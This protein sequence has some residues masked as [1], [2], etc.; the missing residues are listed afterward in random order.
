LDSGEQRSYI[1]SNAATKLGLHPVGEEK[2]SHTL[3]GGV[4]T[5]AKSVKSYIVTSSNTTGVSMNLNLLKCD[6]ICENLPT[7]NVWS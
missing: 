1:T 7:L 4:C 5:G 3:F 2:L 6:K